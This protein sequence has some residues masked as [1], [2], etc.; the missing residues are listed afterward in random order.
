MT[1]ISKYDMTIKLLGIAT[2]A[3]LLIPIIAQIPAPIATAQSTQDND[4]ALRVAKN[5]QYL[6]EAE[7]AYEQI[8]QH[9]AKVAEYEKQQ[10]NAKSEQEKQDLEKKI[11]QVWQR[12][13]GLKNV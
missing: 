6:A 3:L 9:L 13:L 10:E 1:N 2:A 12:S 7:A 4:T 5:E 8:D 11:K